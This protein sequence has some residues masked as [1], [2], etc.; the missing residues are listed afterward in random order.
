MKR[1]PEAYKEE[2]LQ[3][4]RHFESTRQVFQLKTVTP[5][6]I[7]DFGALVTFLS[8]VTPCFKDSKPEYPKALFNLLQDKFEVLEPGLRII[9]VQ[10]LILLQNRDM[11]S[12]FDLLPLFFKLFRC[13]DKALRKL[14]FA[15]IVNDI[16]RVNQHGKNPKINN[17]LQ[18]FMFTMLKDEN[19]MAARK[20]LAVMIELWRRNVW[21][22]DKL[23]NAISTA[24]FSK[25]SQILALSLR[26]FLGVEIVDDEADFDDVNASV[27]LK[28][29]A[30]SDA[31]VK[32]VKRR[33]K[34]KREHAR[35]VAKIKRQEKEKGRERDNYNFKA[36]DLIYDPQTFAERLFGQVKKS[37]EAF[38]TR[39]LMMNVISRL[40]GS[41]KLLLFNFYPFLQN[42]MQSHQKDVTY[43]L[44]FLAQATHDLVPPEIL[45]PCV[46][47]LA[48]NFVTDRSSPEVMAV[49]LNTI[50]EVC[51]RAPLV[52]SAEL[53]S[54]LAQY[55]KSK[56]KGVMMA[57]RSL[58]AL[59][60]EINPTILVKKD[61][62]KSAQMSLSENGDQSLEYGAF[63]ASSDVS[64]AQ[65]LAEAEAEEYQGY[66]S[67]VEGDEW[68][69]KEIDSEDS[70]DGIDIGDMEMVEDTPKIAKK[71]TMR[72]AK[73]KKLRR[74]K[75][76]AALRGEVVEE[77]DEKVEE[78]GEN[79]AVDEEADEEEFEIEIVEETKADAN[80]EDLNEDEESEEEKEEKPTILYGT[81]KI[82][83]PKDF[84]RIRQL[85]A[86]QAMDKKNPHKRRREDG[87]TLASK[88][89]E[90]VDPDDLIGWQ[91]KKRL[92]YEER[93]ASIL[94][95]RE[96][97]GSYSTPKER[98]GG[99]TNKDKLKNKPFMMINKSRKVKYKATKAFNQK[100]ESTTKHI[101]AMKSMSKKK[102]KSLKRKKGGRKVGS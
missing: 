26:F 23:V 83:T 47:T 85:K 64:G 5:K 35:A 42:Y 82:L 11:A 62:G 46:K 56:E 48:N 100:Q 40:V 89:S 97:R 84:E 13:H 8:H 75:R 54:D 93:W 39:L 12:R 10:A 60:R 74:Q 87:S 2:F 68:E 65:L 30:F 29:L 95:G 57:A 49:G 41:H 59:F 38:A 86:E 50:R 25:D 101:K 44:A 36:I 71:K 37:R 96:G 102:R 7:K 91:K 61:R 53:L 88:D 28:E 21:T 20:S 32:H 80:A 51:T 19:P 34:R 94:E 58:I 72:T 90:T 1:D 17:S 6:Q 43:I 4:Y 70:D 78:V 92:T 33:N 63:R 79:E 66:N 14:L 69:E 52:M 16:R 55:K 77:A 22:G 3:Q 9:M 98:G 27:K 81:Q 45:V 73:A 18:S 67:D 31:N 99:S 24:C 15:H 76:D